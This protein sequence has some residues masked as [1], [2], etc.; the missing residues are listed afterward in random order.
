MSRE[1]IFVGLQG[2]D[3]PAR[4]TK[5]GQEC[6]LVF[7]MLSD[8]QKCWRKVCDFMPRQALTVRYIAILFLE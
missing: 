8:K 5:A 6:S 7:K 4:G 2:S 1:A 3:I